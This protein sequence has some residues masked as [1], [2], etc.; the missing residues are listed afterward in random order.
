MVAVY[1]LWMASMSALEGR[2]ITSMMRSIWLMVEVP[3]NTGR[4]LIISPKMVATAQMS[5]PRVYSVEPS[6]ISVRKERKAK[7]KFER[8]RGQ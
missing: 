8:Q 4:P 1:T 2:L 3:G 6:R 5:T 7:R